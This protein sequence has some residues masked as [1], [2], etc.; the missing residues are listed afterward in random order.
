MGGGGSRSRGYRRSGYRQLCIYVDWDTYISLVMHSKREGRTMSDIVMEAIRKY[1]GGGG[2]TAN[3]T[4]RVVAQEV[5]AA[6][7]GGGRE[8]A[9]Q[10]VGQPASQQAD[11]LVDNPWVEILRKRQY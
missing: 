3:T 11:W 6:G 7:S 9:V 8:L 4:G 10:Q 5:V 1:L 2:K